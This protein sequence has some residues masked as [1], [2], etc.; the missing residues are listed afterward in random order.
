MKSHELAVFLM[1]APSKKIE[2][3]VEDNKGEVKKAAPLID[4]RREEVIELRLKVF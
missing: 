4:I 2:F 1:R 3:V